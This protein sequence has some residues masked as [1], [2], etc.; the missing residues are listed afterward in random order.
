MRVFEKLVSFCMPLIMLT[1]VIFCVIV[2]ADAHAALTLDDLKQITNTAKSPSPTLD[3]PKV[4]YTFS[5]DS[6][7]AWRGIEDAINNSAQNQIMMHISGFGGSTFLG[8]EVVQII[9][10][11]KAHG[12][13]VEM[14]VEGPSMSMHALL[15]CSASSYKLLPGASL[16]FHNMFSYGEYFGGALTLKNKPETN[17][18]MVAMYYE[19]LLDCVDNKILTKDDVQAILTGHEVYISNLH[20]ETIKTVIADPSAIESISSFVIQGLCNVLTYLYYGV[21]LAAIGFLISRAVRRN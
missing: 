1:V 15:V 9:R 7:E 6:F 21:L 11:A 18:S 2:H 5:G 12:K 4:P 8:H 3:I 10:T 17:P 13:T 19:M 16:M 20:G 14:I